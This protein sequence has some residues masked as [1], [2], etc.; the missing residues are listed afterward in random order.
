MGVGA[1]QVSVHERRHAVK[2]TETELAADPSP[3]DVGGDP[4]P[5][6]QVPEASRCLRRIIPELLSCL[7]CP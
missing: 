3:A 2:R 5:W 6:R 7:F 1:G 4:E